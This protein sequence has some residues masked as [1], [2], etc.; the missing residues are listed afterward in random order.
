MSMRE[1]A[2]RKGTEWKQRKGG[3]RVKEPERKTDKRAERQTGKLMTEDNRRE[4]KGN[5]R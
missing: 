3:R 4:T 1:G 2:R 5:D